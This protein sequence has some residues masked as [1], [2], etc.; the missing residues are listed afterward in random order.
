VA[1]GAPWDSD[2][3]FRLSRPSAL[4]GNEVVR[5][6]QVFTSDPLRL[7]QVLTSDMATKRVPQRGEDLTSTLT[8]IIAAI[9]VVKNA[10]PIQ[11]GQGILSTTSAILLIVKVSFT[12]YFS[13]AYD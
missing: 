8:R 3:D 1:T 11:L 13:P 2:Q 6:P 7:K 9:D 10:V 5:S 4:S 12:L